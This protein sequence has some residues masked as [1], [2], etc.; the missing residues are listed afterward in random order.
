MLSQPTD[1]SVTADINVSFLF[2]YL[3]GYSWV[4]ESS[5]FVD[6]GM[7]WVLYLKP[8]L[9][10]THTFHKWTPSIRKKITE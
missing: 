5:Q 3:S 8:F 2:F 6:V 4:E 1:A 10:Q 9:Q 7:W